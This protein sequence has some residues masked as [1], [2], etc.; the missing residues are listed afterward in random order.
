MRQGTRKKQVLL[1][2]VLT[3]L[4]VGCMALG[5]PAVAVLGS[6][7]PAGAATTATTAADPVGPLVAQVEG[8]VNNLIANGEYQLCR[9]SLH[10]NGGHGF[11]IPPS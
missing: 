7:A 6:P 9:L 1:R 8:L 4:F 11:C 2:R 3:P 10:L 5:V